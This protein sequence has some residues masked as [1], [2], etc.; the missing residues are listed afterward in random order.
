LLGD[1]QND[2]MQIAVLISTS[3][4]ATPIPTLPNRDAAV[5]S[6]I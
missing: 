6:D 5:F 4:L 2:S 1:A 3:L